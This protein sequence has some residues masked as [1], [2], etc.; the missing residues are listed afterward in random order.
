M[1]KRWELKRR[2][3]VE[4]ISGARGWAS[5]ERQSRG[6]GGWNKQFETESEAWILNKVF[7]FPVWRG[8]HAL[9][10]H[11]TAAPEFVDKVVSWKKARKPPLS[12]TLSAAAVLVS[13]VWAGGEAGNKVTLQ[14]KV[15]LNV[16]ALTWSQILTKVIIYNNT[17]R[18][19]ILFLC[20]M[21]EK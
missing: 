3:V 21:P 18:N 9:L 13:D 6:R 2:T 12:H 1:Q 10:E 15:N 5:G 7:S 17:F 20:R 19:C 8:V 4:Q 14:C 16:A 11:W